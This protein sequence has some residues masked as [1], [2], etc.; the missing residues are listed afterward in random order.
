MMKVP[1]KPTYFSGLDVG[2]AHESTARAVVER[3]LESDPTSRHQSLRHY[4]VRHLHR[5]V[6]GPPNSGLAADV[7]M[8]F[9]GPPLAQ[10]RL[11]VDQTMVAHRWPE[12]G[13]PGFDLLSRYFW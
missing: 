8:L 11:I 7:A 4:A 13:C 1:S 3:T 10:S 9:P 5:F 12:R 6:L 2:Q